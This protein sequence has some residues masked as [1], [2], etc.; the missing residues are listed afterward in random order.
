VL[1]P[2][3]DKMITQEC[4]DYFEEMIKIVSFITYYSPTISAQ[5]WSLFNKL[6]GAFTW[7]GMDLISELLIPFDNYISRGTETFLA[8]PY[9]QMIFELYQKILMDPKTLP[10]HCCDAAK[11]AEVVL[12][13]CRG[14][15]DNFLAGYL[16]CAVHRLLTKAKKNSLKVLLLEVVSHGLYYNV[17][18]TLQILENKGCTQEVFNIW[19]Q[20]IKNFARTHDKKVAI[21]GLSALLTVPPASLPNII[22]AGMRTILQTLVPLMHSLDQQ[23][24]EEMERNESSEEEDDEEDEEL[25]DHDQEDDG[26]SLQQLAQQAQQYYSDLK[27]TDENDE[28]DNNND[29]D[30][31]LEEEEDFTSPID[32]VDEVIQFTEYMKALASNDEKYYQGLLSALDPAGQEAYKGLFELAEKRK[33]EKLQQ[34]QQQQQQQP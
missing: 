27:D 30:D 9:P 1:F 11:L 31:E 22:Q 16:E 14:R 6:Y 21:L 7:F 4:V 20:N 13:N 15:V 19:F 28:D 3:L 12:L 2:F 25:A 8:G 10:E 33:A 26:E 17:A 34:Q 24:K 32:N 23:I 18:A 29:E 5:M